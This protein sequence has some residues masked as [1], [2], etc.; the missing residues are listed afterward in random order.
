MQ[1]QYTQW[2]QIFK[3]FYGE[4][5]LWGRGGCRDLFVPVY[6]RYAL[7]YTHVLMGKSSFDILSPQSI[8]HDKSI[9]L[10]NFHHRS[11]RVRT[12]TYEQPLTSA[13]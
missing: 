6:L 10:I 11:K 7:G 5:R 12:L 8:A 13:H 3:G 9:M 1:T 2:S 4:E